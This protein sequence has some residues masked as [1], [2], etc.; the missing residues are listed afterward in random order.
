MTAVA[1]SLLKKQKTKILMH[2]V[3]E[4]QKLERILKDIMRLEAERQEEV[5]P[6]AVKAR[7]EETMKA[8]DISMSKNMTTALAA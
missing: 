6:E 7:A 3:I 4:K 8:V 5:D 1:R 2:Q